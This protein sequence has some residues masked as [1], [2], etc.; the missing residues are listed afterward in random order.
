MPRLLGLLIV[1]ALSAEMRAAELRAAEAGAPQLQ[2]VVF[3]ENDKNRVDFL[4]Y[5]GPDPAAPTVV[6]IHGGQCTADDWIAVAP[7]LAKRYRVV[8]P[9]GFVVPFDPWRLWL[10]LDHLQVSRAALLGH[11][12]GG[13]VIREMYRLAPDRVWALVDV[14][15][16]AFG[17]LTLART[18]PNDR[19]SPIAAAL[20]EKHKEQMQRLRPGH[21][22]DYPSAVTIERRLVAYERSK[23]SPETRAAARK[24]DQVA[25]LPKPRVAPE[26]IAAE[27]KFIR[28]PCLEIQTGRGKLR[29]ADF[30]PEWVAKNFQADDLRYVLIEESGHWPWLEDLAGFLAILDPFLAAHA[31]K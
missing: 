8:V 11:S 10:L 2:S 18:L 17:P 29:R 21:Q 30:G 22:G 28:C 16:G 4:D 5:P 19:Y 24:I 12:A 27:G 14:D 26:P 3:G 1:V 23:I 9:D 25:R 15:G 7:L 6:L 13:P 31:P 20:Y